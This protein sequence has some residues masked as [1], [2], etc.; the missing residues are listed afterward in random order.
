MDYLANHEHNKKLIITDELTLI[1]HKKVLLEK[2][3]KGDN[4]YV[5]FDTETT[6]TEPRPKKDD[7]G[8]MTPRDRIIEVAFIACEEDQNGI[9][10]PVMV[11]NEPVVFQ[12]YINPSREDAKLIKNFQ[13]RTDNNPDAEKVH[14]ISFDFLNG[15]GTLAGK[16]LPKPAPTFNEIRPFMDDF[17]CLNELAEV[18]GKM[19]CIG[20]NAINFDAIFLSMEMER[21][22][23]VFNEDI[24][25]PRSF[26]SM[27]SNV[28]DTMVMMK[29]LWKRDEL[30][31]YSEGFDVIDAFG[32]PMKAGFSMSYLA[33][34]M[35]VKETGRAEFHGAL[36]DSQILMD[37]FQKFMV[38]PKYTRAVNKLPIKKGA[39]AFLSNKL[40]AEY[41]IAPFG[42]EIVAQENAEPIYI[43]QTDASLQEGTG[44]VKEYV[45]RAQELG[46]KNLLMSDVCSLMEFVPFYESCIENDITP[47][48]AT[49]FKYESLADTFVYLQRNKERNTL[50]T[51][52]QGIEPALIAM[53]NDLNISDVNNLDTFFKSTKFENLL[54]IDELVGALQDSHDKTE[55]HATADAQNKA[56]TA[57]QTKLFAI[58]DQLQPDTYKNAKAIEMSVVE[59]GLTAIGDIKDRHVYDR[60]SDHADL[61]LI[62]NND[63]GMLSLRKL[64]TVTQRDG[65]YF[66]KTGKTRAKGEY[67]LLSTTMLS[68]YANNVSALIGDFNDVVGR[69]LKLKINAVASF[70]YMMLRDI[71]GQENIYIDVNAKMMKEPANFQ[72]GEKLYLEFLSTFSNHY[73]I[74][75]IA[76]HHVSFSEAKD[77][78][79]H[80]NKSAVLLDQKV[81]GLVVRPNR[82]AAQYLIDP[83]DIDTLFSLNGELLNNSQSFIKSIN[84][85]PVLNQP[86]LPDFPTPKG[87]SQVQHLRNET[88]VGFEKRVSMA[89]KKLESTSE[90]MDDFRTRYLERLEFELKIIEDMGF[91]GYFLIV[92]D[93]INFC[94]ENG[95]PIGAGRGSAA[96]S[97][98]VYSLGI[99]DIDPIEFG[100]IFERFLNPERK[101]MPDIDTDLTGDDRERLLNYQL[102][103][104]A[105]YGDGFAAAAYIVTKSTFSAKST[106]QSLGKTKNMSLQWQYGLSDLISDEPGTTLSDELK[107]NEKLEYRYNHEPKTK[108]V[109]DEALELEKEK[110]RQKTT[111]VHAGGIVIGNLVGVAPI[112]YQKG[113]PIIQYDK[114]NVEAAGGVKFDW[115]GLNTLAKLDLAVRLVHQYQGADAL[116][117][118]NITIDGKRVNTSAIRYTDSK[119]YDLL[120]KAQ[121][122]NVFQVESQLFK[123]LIVRI[124]PRSME[125]IAALV[126]L[127]RPGPLESGMDNIYAECKFNPEKIKY[128][129]PLLEPILS[130][131][132][133]AILYQEQV[134]EIAKSLALYT[135]GGADKLRKAMGKKKPEE[136]A[137]QREIFMDGCSKNNI[138]KNLA[139]KIFDN[140]EKF[141]GYGFNKSH[142]VSYGDLTYKTALLKTHFPTEFMSAILSL[143]SLASSKSSEKISKD[144]AASRELGITIIA[145]DIN[146]SK[147]NYTPQ[148]DSI[149]YGLSGIK[150]ASFDKMVI[151]VE[152][153]GS[154]SNLEDVISRTTASKSLLLL[155]HAGAMDKMG[156]CRPLDPELLENIESKHLKIAIKRE[157]LVAEFDILR[158]VMSNASKK[159]KYMALTADEKPAIDYQ[160]VIRQ[161]AANEKKTVTRMLNEENA[162]L[163]AYITAHPMEISGVKEMLSLPHVYPSLTPLSQFDNDDMKQDGK[164]A[165]IAGFVAMSELDLISAAGNKWGK[166][167]LDD[168]TSSTEMIFYASHIELIQEGFKKA[169]G[170][171]FGD[172]DIISLVGRFKDTENKKTG[173][174]EMKFHLDKLEVPELDLKISLENNNNN[175][176]NQ[177]RR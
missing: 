174:M 130:P 165:R 118:F 154:F 152:K 97:L 55:K 164:E 63:D 65:Q 9:L 60:K 101:E 89:Y 112:M 83:E 170:R 3:K 35:N 108:E 123:D 172:G 82:F 143:D 94:H 113:K 67:P 54:A 39:S 86:A 175:N 68:E 33:H 15:K 156:L 23:L 162:V 136:M 20:H 17:L 14:G 137:K 141:A 58:A 12:E 153:N 6:G 29:E 71:L 168:G 158:D 102:E 116:A 69:S 122:T 99:T 119:T 48:I 28:K 150:G 25:F 30:A 36:L 93:A 22:D 59:K 148:G 124:R 128:D 155:I 70:S 121:T 171:P 173:S 7:H 167:T 79:T 50:N 24:P 52:G 16:H 81:E 8:N 157:L 159:K 5:F 95:I 40:E 105:Q 147:V 98:V 176:N 19:I 2:L 144:V 111:G 47:I 46:I 163:S 139:E 160:A 107:N 73:K 31:Q 34:M 26:E 74:K 87:V 135:M 45:A 100:L 169:T 27:I 49:T 64:I 125:E 161:C 166:L 53:F 140:M 145:P 4:V 117:R 43:I 80:L 21:D 88:M 138:D 1:K 85:N 90:A 44:R 57:V 11:D 126:A 32:R 120:C 10:A 78:K 146:A 76:T 134:M 106:I 72:R 92:Q 37:V 132:Y 104:Y 129:H 127:G 149:L 142:A 62:A 84:I 133:G 115:L 18:E 41:K 51:N 109:I 66:L 56:K 131:T 151:E 42:D 103:K 110:G 38:H 77:Y 114:D 13:S 91:S 177:R 61:T 96:G 75:P